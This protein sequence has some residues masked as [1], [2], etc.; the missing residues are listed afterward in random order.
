MSS[1]PYRSRKIGSESLEHVLAAASAQ[2]K[3]Q[4]TLI[5]LHVQTSNADAKRFYERHGFVERGV[6]EDYYKKIEPR[7][8]W[9]LEREIKPSVVSADALG[10]P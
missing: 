3:P 2:T 7:G 10:T 4:I 9:I 6:Q 1:Q 5:S 8:A